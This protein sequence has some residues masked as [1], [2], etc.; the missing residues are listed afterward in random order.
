MPLQGIIVQGIVVTM[1][2]KT[3]K[4]GIIGSSGGSAL[5]AADRCLRSIGVVVDWVVVTDRACGLD[6]WSR[7][8]GHETHLL[9]YESGIAF[10]KAANNVF[11]DAACSDVLMFYTRRVTMPLINERRVWNIH[12]SLLPAFAGLRGVEDAWKAKV[13]IFG[14]TLHLADE[15][16]D[17]GN[18]RAQ[19]A[20]SLKQECSL[21]HLQWL[22]YLQ[23]TWLTLTWFSIVTGEDCRTSII[24]CEPGVGLASPGLPT[25]L[26]V[27]Y[28][29]W[30]QRE[31]EAFA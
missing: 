28:F 3:F 21:Q 6:R 25:E 22:S 24:S 19:V 31:Q 30:V 20:A 26:H 23:K 15:G 16:L 2:T 5:I 10:S 11:K 8:A 27:A 4:L 7:G 1:I 14:A 9:H 18:I 13:T 17:T 29:N 12:P